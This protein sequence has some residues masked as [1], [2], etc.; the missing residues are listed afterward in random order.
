MSDRQLSQ[1]Q[2]TLSECGHG[3]M[4]KAPLPRLPPLSPNLRHSDYFHK[5]RCS[6]L[7]PS[8]PVPGTG[9]FLQLS[10]WGRAEGG[11]GRKEGREGAN[12]S[13]LGSRFQTS[14]TS[15]L[16]GLVCMLGPPVARARVWPWTQQ[17]LELPGDS[18][19]PARG[20][21]GSRVRL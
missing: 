10:L 3:P 16:L 1:T 15:A 18:A 21:G 7:Y 13:E 4:R 17:F 11:K 14:P 5:G 19:V 2:E 20:K 6:P 8:C 9:L 12:A